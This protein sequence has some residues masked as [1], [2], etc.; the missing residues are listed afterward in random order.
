MIGSILDADDDWIEGFRRWLYPKLHPYLT[1]VNG[2]GVGTVG[3]AQYVCTLPAGEEHVEEVLVDHG[4]TRN[5]IACYKTHADGR[6]S[7]GSWRLR[8]LDDRYDLLEDSSKQLHITFFDA[9]DQGAVDVY[10]HQEYDWMCA[11]L[12]HL[13][14]VELEFDIGRWK[15]KR[16]IRDHTDLEW[17]DR[18]N[19]SD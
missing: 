19:R 4:W 5:P 6:Q 14:E 8:G 16:F 11:P 12:M 10:C 18:S 2:Y 9:D 13:R 7:E 17:Y 15:A 1:R 3:E